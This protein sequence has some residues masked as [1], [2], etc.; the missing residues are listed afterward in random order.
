MAEGKRD[1]QVNIRFAK[2][3]LERLRKAARQIGLKLSEW[4]RIELRKA[5]KRINER[6]ER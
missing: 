6:G 2:D 5:A 1:A 4:A 3:E